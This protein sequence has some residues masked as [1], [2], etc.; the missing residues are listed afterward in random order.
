MFCQIYCQKPCF[1]V[2]NPKSIFF[3]SKLICLL[4]TSSETLVANTQFS[5][6]LA[7]VL[8]PV[9]YTIRQKKTKS[10]ALENM[11]IWVCVKCIEETCTLKCTFLFLDKHLRLPYKNSKKQ[12]THNIDSNTL[13]FSYSSFVDRNA[14][15][16][17]KSTLCD[18]SLKSARAAVNS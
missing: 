4:A 12:L 15:E 8:G 6:A 10:W 2:L 13:V 3:K 5:V 16:H 9:L 18:A 1:H 14:E 7:P 17:R 11:E